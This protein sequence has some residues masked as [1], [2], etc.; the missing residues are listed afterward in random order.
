MDEKEFGKKLSLL[1]TKAMKQGMCLSIEDIKETFPELSENEEQMGHLLTYF[2][3]SKIAVGD[4]QEVDDFLSMEDQNYLDQYI[5][6]LSACKSLSK[7]ELSNA[8]R[9]TLNGEANASLDF[10]NHFLLEVIPL[11]K[12]YAGQGVLL[13]DLI[14]E[15]NLAL[16]EATLQLGCIDTD[17]NLAQ[18][19]EGFVG[20]YMM[21]AM[22]LLING[23]LAEKQTD[24]EIAEKVNRVFDVAKQLYEDV[25]RK[26][27][28]LE[29]CENSDLTL[30]AV[31]EAIR[32]S[33][34]RIEEIEIGEDEDGV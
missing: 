7:E 3:S 9:G 24:E 4:Q 22:E 30:E 26:V 33:G 25:R 14:G 10:M 18:E 29:I 5:E 21:D 8:V 13:E 11:A 16:T 27:T 19:A 28:P 32:L 2:K 34:K 31:Y 17:G 20:K 6:E 23:E 1:K 15:G 12:L